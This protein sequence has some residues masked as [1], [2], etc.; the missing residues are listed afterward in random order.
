MWDLWWTK[1][2]WDRLSPNSLVPLP[3]LILP[4]VPH[5]LIILLLT[6]YCLDTCIVV[7]QQTNTYECIG[8]IVASIVRETSGSSDT[9]ITTCKTTVLQPRKSRSEFCMLVIHPGLDWHEKL[10]SA[11]HALITVSVLSLRVFFM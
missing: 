10:I 4:T 11:E 1:W 6:L 8:G 5:S 7:K 2:H 3:V 9:V